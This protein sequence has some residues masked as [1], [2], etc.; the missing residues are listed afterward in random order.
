[1]KQGTAI[2][3]L[4]ATLRQ[5]Y[6]HKR[7]RARDF[8]GFLALPGGEVD[9][10]ETPSEAAIRELKEETKLV[11]TKADISFLCKTRETKNPE[12]KWETFWFV[13][14]LKFGER[15]EQAEKRKAGKWKAYPLAAIRKLKS[16][17]YPGT[18]AVLK[19]ANDYAEA[20]SPTNTAAPF[21]CAIA[22]VDI[23][24]IRRNPKDMRIQVLLGRKPGAKKFRFPGGFV[25]PTQDNTFKDAAL[26]E[27]SEE[28]LNCQ[29]LPGTDKAIC[30]GHKVNDARYSRDKDKIFTSLF[31]FR[32]LP[33]GK[34]IKAGDD[35]AAVQWF[36]LN[37]F[38]RHQMVREH[39][40][41]LTELRLEAN[42]IL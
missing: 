9:P 16:Q 29:V 32:Y 34:R 23:A 8:N 35:L 27:L 39:W 18:A 10:G 25:D 20:M 31:V 28:V 4:D 15:M 22:A 5:V 2:I 11:R 13:T 14:V 37:T 30:T 21:K 40:F 41:L 7:L 24:V 38:K 6:L 12:D 36:D 1:M 19:K 33:T 17:L 42:H 3:V 26:R